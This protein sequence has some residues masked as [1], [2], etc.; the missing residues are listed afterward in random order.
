MR[1]GDKV[2]NLGR[3]ASHRRALMSNLTSQLIE[4]KRIITTLAKAKA[5]RKYA[6]PIINRA[7]EDSTHN[8]RIVFSYLQNKESI[9]E[10]FSTISEKIAD[11]P[12]GYTRIV[13]LAP[14]MGD[15][16]EMALIELVD[17][18]ELYTKEGRD[19][20]AKKTRRSRRGGKGR[21]TGTDNPPTATGDM[22]AT[23]V[24][25]AGAARV[26]AS[27]QGKEGVTG[28]D[29]DDNTGNPQVTEPT[30]DASVETGEND[31]AAQEIAATEDNAKEEGATGE[32]PATDE[33]TA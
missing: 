8:R 20:G 33:A 18:N 11:R 6:E 4:Y 12:G 21:T 24:A 19:A 25:V 14:R 17:F 32:G 9:K 2:K 1:H 15:A 29:S 10:L 5:L 16:A 22:A 27:N 31:G 3:T 26:L 7:K 30:T 23:A 13:K 28:D